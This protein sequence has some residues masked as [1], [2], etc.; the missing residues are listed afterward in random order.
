MSALSVM[1]V[2][3]PHS[4]RVLNCVFSLGIIFGTDWSMESEKAKSV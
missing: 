1:Q 4:E 3:V 2:F